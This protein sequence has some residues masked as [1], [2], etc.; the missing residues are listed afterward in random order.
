MRSLARLLPFS[1][2]DDVP[3][4]LTRLLL[5]AGATLSGRRDRE[6]R[7][8]LHLHL[9]LLEE[10]YAAEGLSPDEARQRA[11]RE[12][13]NAAAFQQAC[14]DLF[15]FR[16]VE[17]FIQDLRYAIREIRRSPGFT[18]VAVMSLAVGIGSLTTT[19]SI[20]DAFMLRGLPVHEPDRLVAVSTAESARWGSWSYA[21]FTRWRESPDRLFDAAAASDVRE[22]DVRLLGSDQ[23]SEVRVTLVSSNYFEVMG[24]EVRVGRALTD[25][26]EISRGTEPVA[27]ISDAFWERWFGR[28]P[29]ILMKSIDVQ[30]R[31][32]AIVGVAAKPFSGHA[33][34]QPA[35]VWIPLVRQ[36][37]LM[38][39]SPNLLEGRGALETKWL[40]VVGRL[41]ANI[42]VREATVL[43]NLI[44]QRFIAAKVT[45]FGETSPEVVRDRKQVVSLLSA[46]TGFAP[47][48]ARY[49]RPLMFLS[50]I[51]ALVFLV[52][53]ANFT[54]L[55]VA[56]TERRRREFAIRLALGGGRGRLIRQSMAECALLAVVAGTLG[57]L[58]AQWATTAA[59][60]QFAAMIIPIELSL[61]LDVRVLAFAAGA[62]AAVVGFGLVP[63]ILQ[64]GSAGASAVYQN[65]HAYG[66]GRTRAIA[67]RI[68]LIAQMAMCVILLIG[69]GLLLRTVMNLRSQ[70]LGF[71]RNV[72]LVPISSHQAGYTDEAAAIL[73][74][75]IRER[76]SAVPGVQTVAV[77]GAALL[78][79]TNYWIDDSTQLSTDR[80]MALPGTRWTA[81]SVGPDFFKAVGISILHG[82]GFIDQ[83]G[84]PPYDAVI[85]N[86][87]LATL[88]YGNEN[89]L[90]R[91]LRMNPR[92]PMLSVVG[93]A[94]D[95]KQTSPRDRGMGVIYE[96]VRGYGRVVLA[97]R[98][99]GSPAAIAPVV[100][101]QIGSLASDLSMDKVRTIA[102]VLDAAIAQ[103]RLMSGIALVLAALVIATGCVGLYALMSCDVAQRTHEL[104][105]RLTLGATSGSVALLILRDVVKLV[106]P[107]LIIG[108]P[109]GVIASRPLASQLYGVA[110]TDPWTLTS[111]ALLL[112]VFALVATVRPA[113]TASRIDPIAL[114]RSE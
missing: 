52:A 98:T 42:R 60:R 86:R 95:A 53:C 114:L 67:G 35:D 16:F 103:E 55:M 48:R 87:S 59:L 14:H 113:L 70:E 64:A 33:V 49:A 45:E 110:S 31:S 32:Y 6:L 29:D 20:I 38:P 78:D 2:R 27:M 75:R 54:N 108:I 46:T 17:N 69:A 61:E 90:G 30:G 63:C 4:W 112:T 19:F 107:S 109:L 101:H 21:A 85:I 99:A 111:V 1:R 37:E 7:D 25:A 8:E 83:D 51:T 18:C 102:E 72:L 65:T 58:L 62:V 96:P 41:R 97:I 88:L 12:F 56:R 81:A 105:V 23:P 24:A 66:A 94:S 84:R 82:R 71:D 74:T 43:A 39:G 93:I 77:S 10:E 106:L 15:S 40:K 73:V 68:V 47:E 13:G 76:L 79:V 91:R 50:G 34:G 3:V 11:R 80:G 44:Y 9:R 5:R 22:Y 104:G 36:P 26:D 92:S 89:P 28:T 100:A 57:L